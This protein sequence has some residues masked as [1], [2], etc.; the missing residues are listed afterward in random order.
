MVGT[1]AVHTAFVTLVTVP[2]G[3]GALCLALFAGDLGP[4]SPG[5]CRLHVAQ[6]L[7]VA[8]G[9]PDWPR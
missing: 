4:N 1:V 7:Q 5:S 8:R 6:M 3:D 2:H 9:T